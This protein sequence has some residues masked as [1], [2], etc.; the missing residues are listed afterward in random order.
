MRMQDFLIERLTRA[1]GWTTGLIA[2]IDESQWFE[3]PAPGVGHV[4]WQLGHLAVSQ[5]ALIHVRCL[6]KSAA[7]CIDPALVGTFGKGSTPV[8]DASE[9]PSIAEIRKLFDETQRDVIEIIRGMSD[10]DL[11]APAGTEPHP[12]FDTRAGALGT[13]AMHETFHAGQIAMSRRIWGRKPLR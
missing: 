10:A 6:G 8:A 12:L 4:A 11:E 2:D 5:I 13:A 3:M 9:Y 1:R 7:E